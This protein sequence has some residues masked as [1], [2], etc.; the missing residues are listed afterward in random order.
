[1]NGTI[2]SLS[3]PPS[4]SPE[5]SEQM[6]TLTLCGSGESSDAH[7]PSPSIPNITT[8]SS[9]TYLNKDSIKTMTDFS[10]TNNYADSADSLIDQPGPSTISTDADVLPQKDCCSPQFKIHKSRNQKKLKSG[11]EDV[12]SN[13][14]ALSLSTN[15]EVS[16]LSSQVRTW[17][18][19]Y[20]SQTSTSD[21]QALVMNVCLQIIHFSSLYS[22]AKYHSLVIQFLSPLS[23]LPVQ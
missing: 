20:H 6:P 21:P 8:M 17:P 4:Q 11:T 9:S 7:C 16:S 19:L 18:G 12:S 3:R 14:Q 2:R 1:M 23:A 22:Q 15:V 5:L 13:V 10:V